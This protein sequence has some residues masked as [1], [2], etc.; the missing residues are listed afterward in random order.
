[1]SNNFIFSVLYV[2]IKIEKV[3]VKVYNLSIISKKDFKKSFFC[4]LDNIIFAARNEL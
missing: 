1:M 3:M 2:K 4:N